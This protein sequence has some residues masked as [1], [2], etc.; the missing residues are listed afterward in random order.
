MAFLQI[1]GLSWLLVGGVVV[2]GAV[3]A[4]RSK[5]Q[6]DIH[7][8][9]LRQQSEA[10][11]TRNKGETAIYRNKQAP[12]GTP[13]VS[14]YSKEVKTSYEAFWDAVKRRGTAKYLARKVGDVYAWYSYKE[15]GERVSNFGAGLLKATTV[16]PLPRRGVDPTSEQMV[17]IFLRNC[18]E[19]AITDFACCTYGL[20][21]VPLYDT[22]DQDSLQYIVEHTGLTVIM[23]SA[24]HLEKLLNVASSCSIVKHAIVIDLHV[25]PNEILERAK[26]LNISVTP[27]RDIESIGKSNP[28]PHVPP[29]VD[30]VF[31]I[32][33][34]SGTTGRPKGAML[35]FKNIVAGGAGFNAT[36]PAKDKLNPSDRHFSYLPL[37]HMFERI[38]FHTLTWFGCEIGF[39]QG[40]IA[41]LFDDVALFKPTLFA[42]VPRLMNRLRDKV[43]LTVEQNGGIKKVLFDL[44]YSRKEKVL[45]SGRV[46]TESFWDG[47]VFKKIQARLG[48]RVRFFLVGAAPSSPEVLEFFRIVMGCPVMEGFGQTET[49][50]AGLV[51]MMADYDTPYGSH[52]GHPMASTEIKLVDVP[53]MD[54]YA[55]DVP[56]PRGELCFKGPLLMKG[57]YQASEETAKTI[58]ADGWLHTGDIAEILP[59][60]TVKIIDRLKNFFKLSQ[61]E[62]VAP[63]KVE[64]KIKNKYIAQTFVYGDSLRNSAVVIVVP[65]PEALL[66]WAKA[67][68]LGDLTFEQLCEN[69]TAKKMV[70]DECI[71]T[72]KRGGLLS[73]ELPKSIHMVPKPFTVENGLLTPTFKVKRHE[74]KKQMLKAIEGMYKSID[75]K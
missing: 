25:I 26:A 27:M 3:L 6:P 66:P 36:L 30:D 73:F 32:S 55:A 47:L 39:F 35:K 62:Y 43:L 63:E 67:N 75:G 54:Y 65:D 70:L 15:I 45:R 10:S 24:T 44:A 59:N 72:G 42:T 71:A 49:S 4:Q 74:A 9:L 64:A 17:G 14:T 53:S 7:P 23:V 57:Y 31:T 68:G 11:P 8:A 46:T 58:D 40:E 56:N 12:H 19:W 2:L 50:A 34:T 41:Q 33:Y 1:D 21:S 60:G 61:G 13:L 5:Q 18:P 69:P 48:G 20:V 16:K 38:V 29:D 28:H 52:V 37:A 51:A 22:F